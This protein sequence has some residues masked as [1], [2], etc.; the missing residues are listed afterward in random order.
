MERTQK[1]SVQLYPHFI[2]DANVDRFPKKLLSCWCE[3]VLAS[4][5]PFECI[6]KMATQ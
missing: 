4:L 1:E 3:T 6:L 2:H 5:K